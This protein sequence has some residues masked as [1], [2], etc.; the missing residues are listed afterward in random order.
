[1][2]R[3]RQVPMQADLFDEAEV[4]FEIEESFVAR[5]RAELVATLAQARGAETLPWPDLTSPTLAEMRCHSIAKWLPAAEADGLRAEF[6]AE[7]LRLWR[8]AGEA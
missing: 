6:A 1:M 4:G 8:A 5:I 7:M 2:G 3:G